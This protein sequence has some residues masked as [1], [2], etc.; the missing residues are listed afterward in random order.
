[1]TLSPLTATALAAAI[2]AAAAVLAFAHLPHL[3]VWAAFI[4]WASFDHSGAD[5]HA[6]IRSSAALVFGVVSAW[7]VALTVA[8]GALPLA[9]PLATAISAGVASFLIVVASRLPLLAIV[10]A[11]FYGFAATFAYLSLAPGAFTVDAMTRLDWHNAIVV[12]PI[13]LLIGTTLGIAHARLATL[14]QSETVTGP[15]RV[16]R[17]AAP[18]ARE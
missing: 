2:I 3:L 14:L 15:A 9:T 17:A 7:T 8:A 16:G 1:M 10:P 18:P 4:G 5:L 12:V 6:A 11:T 13:S